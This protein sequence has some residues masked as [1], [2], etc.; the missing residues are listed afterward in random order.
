MNRPSNDSAGANAIEWAIT[1]SPPARSPI[2]ANARSMLASSVT[3]HSTTMSEPTVS[4]SFRTLSSRR[5][6]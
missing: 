4:A 3:S 2:S 6:P 1:S 5:S